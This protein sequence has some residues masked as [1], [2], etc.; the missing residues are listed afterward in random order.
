MKAKMAECYENGLIDGRGGVTKR[1]ENQTF[2]ACYAQGYAHGESQRLRM[3]RDLA[4]VQACR[5]KRLA[6]NN[7]Q[8]AAALLERQGTYLAAELNTFKQE[9][10]D[11][12]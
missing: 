12:L 7:G 1:Q 10:L 2:G 8:A 6:E 4:D 5:A 11:R 9:A 3:Q